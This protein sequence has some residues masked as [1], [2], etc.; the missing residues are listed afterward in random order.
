MGTLFELLR[1][2]ANATAEAAVGFLFSEDAPTGH[3]EQDTGKQRRSRDSTDSAEMKS[4]GQAQD[5]PLDTICADITESMDKL[6]AGHD[7]Q[8]EGFSL[9]LDSPNHGEGIDHSR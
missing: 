3:E 2:L 4:G 5:S 9:T 8:G 1:R 6:G 7:H